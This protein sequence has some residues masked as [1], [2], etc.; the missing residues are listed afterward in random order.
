MLKQRLGQ[1]LLVLELSELHM[2]PILK[3]MTNNFILVA[4][5]MNLL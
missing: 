4:L 1:T 3:E 5:A 2:L